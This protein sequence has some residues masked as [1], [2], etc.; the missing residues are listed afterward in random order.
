MLTSWILLVLAAGTPQSP[1]PVSATV[2]ELHFVC[3]QHGIE[4]V[5]LTRGAEANFRVP[6]D[7]PDGGATWTL[8]LDCREHCRGTLSAESGLLARIDGP[9]KKDEFLTLKPQPNAPASLPLLAV[10]LV[11]QVKTEAPVV[12][13]PPIQLV[14]SS[15]T[16]SKM[17]FLDEGL[18]TIDLDEGRFLAFQATRVDA[19]RARLVVTIERTGKPQE[20]QRLFDKVLKLGSEEVPFDCGR[21]PGFCSGEA[22]LLLREHRMSPK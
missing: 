11:E 16:D 5:A 1:P 22:R 21:T 3:K 2:V 10:K 7:C 20:R 4:P 13:P 9:A 14:L 15:A 12:R 8:S 6:A 19:K 17:F 18:A